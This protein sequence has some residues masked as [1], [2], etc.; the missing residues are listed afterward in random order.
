MQEKKNDTAGAEE[1]DYYMNRKRLLQEQDNETIA[2]T[3][4]RDYCK[5]RRTRL[6]PKQNKEYWRSRGTRLLQEQ[7]NWSTAG[8]EE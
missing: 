3:K 4:E 1:R 2:G 8:V 5:S 7:K 6:L